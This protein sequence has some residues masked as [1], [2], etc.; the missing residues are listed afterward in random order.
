MTLSSLAQPQAPDWVNVELSTPDRASG[1]VGI[2]GDGTIA[3]IEIN[4]GMA[5]VYR[6]TIDGDV[7]LVIEHVGTMGD[8]GWPG[9]NMPVTDNGVVISYVRDPINGGWEKYADDVL[10]N[11]ASGT[12]FV[13]IAGQDKVID[14]AQSASGFGQL[15]EF[16]ISNSTRSVFPYANAYSNFNP[17]AASDAGL[18]FTQAQGVDPADTG[19]YTWD[20]GV[21]TPE[22]VVGLPA[23][24]SVNDGFSG[25]DIK[26][27]K[28]VYFYQ[29]VQGP[30]GNQ[31]V[32]VTRD[33]VTNI[34]TNI[35]FPSGGFDPDISVDD[36]G[37][38]IYARSEL[39]VR[40]LYLFDGIGESPLTENLVNN[41]QPNMNS[42][43]QAVYV[44]SPQNCAIANSSD[45][46]CKSDV[47]YYDINTSQ[48]K[49]VTNMP[50][51]TFVWNA[52]INSMGD[53]VYMFADKPN[54]SS[55]NENNPAL[56]V[57][58]AIID[59][60][61][62][63]APSNL[64]ATPASQTQ[65]NLAWNNSTE[66]VALD[67]Y[68]VFR[69]DVLIASTESTMFQDV[70]LRDA[71]YF[72]YRI[73]AVDVAGNR[74]ASSSSVTASTWPHTDPGGGSGALN[75]FLLLLASILW[76]QRRKRDR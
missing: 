4:A 6:R 12:N 66:A 74:S 27:T 41:N 24:Y 49:Q 8:I 30:N 44:K 32:V 62:P 59:V 61:A 3:W 46:A 16:N 18:V 64:T 38:S 54:A 42:T 71:T 69:N 22:P 26:G 14:T 33:L 29:A 45:P 75:A 15:V 9:L 53:I 36:L 21:L 11:F 13:L 58:A 47:Y 35:V 50:A 7:T 31:I 72:T 23:G 1:H 17:W 19:F 68:D 37:R 10:A 34:G 52:K 48:E 43:G 5:Q 67:S 65:I 2:G 76:V 39:G 40:T 60:I 63:S 25:A 55:N 56:S 51:G 57:G 20:N 28:L 70:G 73:E